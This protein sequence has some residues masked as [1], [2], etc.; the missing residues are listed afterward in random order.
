VNQEQD[1][2]IVNCYGLSSS[3]ALSPHGHND[4][5]TKV[6]KDIPSSLNM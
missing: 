6:K 1:H 3:E 4:H 5:Q 2:K